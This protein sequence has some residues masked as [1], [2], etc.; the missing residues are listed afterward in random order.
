[1]KTATVSRGQP[2]V[3]GRPRW[4]AFLIC[5]ALALAALL[6]LGAV[7]QMAGSYSA[8]NRLAAEGW[9][10]GA[11][12]IVRTRIAALWHGAFIALCAGAFFLLLSGRRAGWSFLQ[13]AMARWGLVLVMAADAILLARH[14]VHSMPRT[15][16]QEN[17]VVRLLKTGIPDKRVAMLTQEG[18]YNNWLTYLFPYHGIK[19]VNITQMPRMPAEYERF[20]QAVG[21]HPL[22][23]WQLSAV[24]YVMAPVGAWNQIQADPNMKDAFAPALEYN[25]GLRDGDLVVVPATAYSPGQHVVL[26]FRK[27]APYAALFAGWA[28]ANDDEALRR[29]AD[30]AVEPFQVL[31]VAPETADDLPASQAQGLTGQARVLAYRSG[32]MRIGISADRPAILRVAEKFDP[33]WQ[34]RVDG[35][36][37]PVRRVDFLFMGVAVAPGDHE[38]ELCYR[39]GAGSLYVLGLGVLLCGGAALS[40]LVRRPAGEAAHG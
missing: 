36:P 6:A 20:L 35:R 39:S 33:G 18:F 8:A 38:V 17:E 21:R 22:R 16:V 5:G 14:Y 24:G 32:R 25:V 2:E 40:L 29:L 15:A 26:A 27:P 31:Q 10:D 30:P 28:A 4:L 1:M 19:S 12:I 23:F 34:A 13:V 37:A 7:T 9:G 3:V 11:Q